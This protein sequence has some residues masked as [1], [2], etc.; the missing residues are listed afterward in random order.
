MQTINTLLLSGGGIK[1]ISYCGVLKKIHELMESGSENVKI[2]IKT[3]CC[4]S[5]GCLFGLVYTIGYKYEEIEDEIMSK[6]FAHLKDVKISNLLRQFGLDSG[7]N[8]MSW[9]ETM[10]IKKG[11]YK[12]TTFKELYER[13]GINLKIITTNL[14]RYTQTIFDKDSEPEYEVLSAIRMSIS[15]PFIFTIKKYNEDIHVDG[16]L[17]DNY[18]I[19]LFKEEI[20]NVLGIHLSNI[21]KT[22]NKIQIRDID[23]YIFN[24]FYCLLVNKDLHY[25]NNTIF[26]D[27]TITIDTELEIGNTMNF[28]LSIDEKRRLIKIGYDTVDKYFDKME[29]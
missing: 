2:D 28:D 3:I 26:K 14:N 22:N 27:K 7:E 4:I 5:V 29:K 15:V 21:K 9:I 1:G 19:H 12:T 23:K 25:Y 16:G 6:N 10:M 18:P 17:I 8:I 24:V 11:Y 20:D 13:T